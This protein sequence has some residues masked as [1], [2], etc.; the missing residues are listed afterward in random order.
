MKHEDKTRPA[1][2]PPLS[3]QQAPGQGPLF[4]IPLHPEAK[5]KHVIAVGS[6]KGGVGKSTITSILAVM[7]AKRGLAVGLM[8]ADLTGP[9]IPQA[10][11]IHE[12]ATGQETTIHPIRTR[13]GIQIISMNILL[14][15]PAKPVVW[16][17]PVIGTVIKQFWSQVV[18]EDVD[19]LLIDMPPGTGDVPLTLYQSLPIAGMIMVSTPQDL[20]SLIVQKAGRMADMMHVPLLGLV[21]NMSFLRCVHCQELIYPFGKGR[22][23]QAAASLSVPLLDELP[24]DPLYA[25]LVDSGQIEDVPGVQL[26][27]TLQAVLD[28]CGLT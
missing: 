17:G 14:D 18:W 28:C 3:G 21:E 13:S 22:A 15:D 11:G 1:A 12:Q 2:K 19:V 6:G 9:S 5:V 4:S 27:K 20:V 26:E 25:A 24:I 8:D 10:F 23:D 16:R 7:L